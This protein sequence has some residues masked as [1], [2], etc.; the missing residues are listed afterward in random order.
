MLIVLFVMKRDRDRSFKEGV[1]FGES[2][3][4][5]KNATE[6]EVI[7][8]SARNVAACTWQRKRTT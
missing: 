5:E 6:L 2:L 7:Q 1:K 3:Y 4:A 8:A